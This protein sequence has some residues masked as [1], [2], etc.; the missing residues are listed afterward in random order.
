MH[1]YFIYFEKVVYHHLS[2]AYPLITTVE[3]QLLRNIFYQIDRKFRH[4]FPLL[5]LTFNALF[6]N[7][8]PTITTPTGCTPFFFFFIIIIII[9]CFSLPTSS[10]EN[11]QTGPHF[12]LCATSSGNIFFHPFLFSLFPRLQAAGV[13][14]LQIINI[15]LFI[16]GY[17]TF[18]SRKFSQTGTHN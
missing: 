10:A 2:A 5:V 7:V 16:Q 4:P 1:A 15:T 13:C 6:S 17:G 8:V 14:E 18:L 3:D 11:Q 12:C 9:N